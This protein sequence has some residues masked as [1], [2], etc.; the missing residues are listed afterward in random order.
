MGLIAPVKVSKNFICPS[1]ANDIEY[2]DL[3]GYNYDGGGI[4]NT[5][6][7]RSLQREIRNWSPQLKTLL[8][9]VPSWKADWISLKPLRY[10]PYKPS[11]FANPVIG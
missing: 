10:K 7:G 9:H 11:L 5:H 1:Y 8:D 3:S 6:L 4:K 2:K